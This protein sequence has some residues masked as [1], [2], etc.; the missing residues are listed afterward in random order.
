MVMKKRSDNMNVLLRAYND[1]FSPLQ[2]TGV[3]ASLSLIIK[4]GLT[5]WVHRHNTLSSC[6]FTFSFEF[7]TYMRGGTNSAK[8]T[9][10][11]LFC[12]TSYLQLRTLAIYWAD[13]C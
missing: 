11:S 6:E 7:K 4:H 2:R 8:K 13:I 1:L 9:T 12:A 10:Q 5:L 3:F